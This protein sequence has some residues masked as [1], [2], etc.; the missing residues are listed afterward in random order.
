MSQAV[1]HEGRHYIFEDGEWFFLASLDKFATRSKVDRS[2]A[3]FDRLTRRFASR[4]EA[5]VQP[6]KAAAPAAS[7]DVGLAHAE[8]A[9]VLLA[10]EK[11]T[12]QVEITSIQAHALDEKTGVIVGLLTKAPLVKEELRHDYNEAITAGATKIQ[13]ALQ[14]RLT[15][16]H[17]GK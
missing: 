7:W 8:I 10:I 3:L 11:A 14:N 17:S 9:G 15:I 6:P 12:T 5:V 2:S 16:I 1:D 13:T 4:R